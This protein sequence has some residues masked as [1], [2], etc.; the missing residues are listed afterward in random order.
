MAGV[1]AESDGFD[2]EINGQG[3][4]V[5]EVLDRPESYLLIFC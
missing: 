2:P 5:G 3:S 1:N 4:E